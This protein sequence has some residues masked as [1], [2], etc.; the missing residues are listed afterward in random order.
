M[1]SLYSGSVEYLIWLE[2]DFPATN[3]LILKKKLDDFD[4]F[5]S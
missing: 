3:I 4:F 5:S 2:N 1:L